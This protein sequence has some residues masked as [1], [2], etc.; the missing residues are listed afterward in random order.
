MN[1]CNYSH[2]IIILIIDLVNAL[3]NA[4]VWYILNNNT[5]NIIVYNLCLGSIDWMGSLAHRMIDYIIDC[6]I[7]YLFYKPYH[8]GLWSCHCRTVVRSVINNIVI[9]CHTA[10]LNQPQLSTVRM[11][12]QFSWAELHR[13]TI[14]GWTQISLYTRL[15]V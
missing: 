2:Y 5:N 11:K 7:C 15:D 14:N 10:T 6:S 9:D 3:V 12:H 13:A 4:V 1:E 8:T